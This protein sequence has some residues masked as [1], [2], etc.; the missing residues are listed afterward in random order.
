MAETVKVVLSGDKEKA[1]MLR[2]FALQRLNVLKEQMRLGGLRQDRRVTLLED[3]SVVECLVVFGTALVNVYAAPFISVKEKEIPEV[4]LGES[5]IFIVEDKDVRYL[6]DPVKFKMTEIPVASYPYENAAKWLDLDSAFEASFLNPGTESLQYRMHNVS[7]FDKFGSYWAVS[8]SRAGGY[9]DLFPT[10]VTRMLSDTLGEV[11]VEKLSGHHYDYKT[12]ETPPGNKITYSTVV[13]NKSVATME[14]STS[15]EELTFKSAWNPIVAGVSQWWSVVR[16]YALTED[17][18]EVTDE[19]VIKHLSYNAWNLWI[20]ENFGSN[21]TDAVQGI[22]NGCHCAF[23]VLDGEWVQSLNTVTGGVPNY[24]NTCDEGMEFSSGASYIINTTMPAFSENVIVQSFDE[25]NNVVMSEVNCAVYTRVEYCNIKMDKEH[26]EETL[27]TVVEPFMYFPA[28]M[29]YSRYRNKDISKTET[30]TSSWAFVKGEVDCTDYYDVDST[31]EYYDCLTEMYSDVWSNKVIIPD[32]GL[33][34]DLII[35]EGNQSYAGCYGYPTGTSSSGKYPIVSFAVGEKFALAGIRRGSELL[36][37][38][39]TKTG[40][41]WGS[42][43][44]V[45]DQVNAAFPQSV[46][47]NLYHGFFLFPKR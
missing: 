46:N 1:E 16:E 18:W 20:Q 34:S 23:K 41:S 45:S 13:T 37:Y 5:F 25:S 27:G 11:I 47:K 2:G 10:A 4:P 43:I 19:E 44:D 24:Y 42:W 32:L 17:G 33:F 29:Y 21:Y 8:V 28:P 6:L 31:I 7:G 30:G 38:L 36:F 14:M 35:S 9:E 15:G 40:D 12:P 3:G 26:S 22:R 39:S